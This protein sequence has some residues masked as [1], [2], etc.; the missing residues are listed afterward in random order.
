MRTSK[1]IGIQICTVEILK[2]TTAA[3]ISSAVVF[4]RNACKIEIKC[5]ACFGG[6]PFLIS[7]SMFSESLVPGPTEPFFKLSRGAINEVPEIL[8]FYVTGI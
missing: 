6:S 1:Y 4:A 3:A 5:W 2:L 8:Q 7:F